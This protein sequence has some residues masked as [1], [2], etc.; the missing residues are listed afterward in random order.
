M[1]AIAETA[2]FSKL[3][4]IRKAAFNAFFVIPELE[5]PHAGRVNQQTAKRQAHKFTVRGRVTPFA[6]VRTDVLYSH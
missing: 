1:L 2:F 5:F 4:N 6:I 3:L